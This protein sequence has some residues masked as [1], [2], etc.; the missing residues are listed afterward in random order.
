MHQAPSTLT[1]RYEVDCSVLQII[2]CVF[3]FYSNLNK[4]V[5][6][7]PFLR[8]HTV[9]NICLVWFQLKYLF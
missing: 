3:A 7:L 8:C 4:N 5:Y 1:K 6:L 2:L 9:L